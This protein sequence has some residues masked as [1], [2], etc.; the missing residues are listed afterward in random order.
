MD[1]IAILKSLLKQYKRS[2]GLIT[3]KLSHLSISRLW[4][5]DNHVTH[6]LLEIV[7]PGL[8]SVKL[9]FVPSAETSERMDSSN[10]ELLKIP[11]QSSAIILS[12]L[13]RKCPRLK[14]LLLV[15][16]GNNALFK[17]A[18]QLLAS[19]EKPHLVELT[20]DDGS[21]QVPDDFVPLISSVALHHAETLQMLAVN[22]WPRRNDR[23][24]F[25]QL[26]GLTDTNS[27]QWSTLNEQSLKTVGLPARCI[28]PQSKDNTMSHLIYYGRAEFTSEKLDMLYSQ[29]IAPIESPQ[30]RAREI[31][32]C[33]WWATPVHPKTIHQYF[34][35]VK[36]VIPHVESLVEHPEGVRLRT[37]LRT[38]A[39]LAL[40]VAPHNDLELLER[41]ENLATKVDSFGSVLEIMLTEAIPNG[42]QNASLPALMQRPF[43]KSKFVQSCNS[44]RSFFFPVLQK[45]CR[46][47]NLLLELLAGDFDV[48]TR[49]ERGF[50]FMDCILKSPKENDCRICMSTI[51]RSPSLLASLVKNMEVTHL[52]LIY[53]TELSP[54][55]SSPLDL[56]LPQRVFQLVEAA[57]SDQVFKIIY[58]YYSDWQYGQITAAIP[59]VHGESRKLPKRVT[60][61]TKEKK[62][63]VKLYRGSVQPSLATEDRIKRFLR[64][65]E[66]FIFPEP[67][68]EETYDDYY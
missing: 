9:S 59:Y 18:M 15:C 26:F 13:K 16:E 29:L 60:A 36:W 27:N 14:T 42:A 48:W 38:V 22:V 40:A 47:L 8:R 64:G 12:L 66:P 7:A 21:Y 39:L 68:E 50:S 62:S 55:Y 24:P 31:M 6:Q 51:F 33:I 49:N 57:D 10:I 67:V 53:S 3:P 30:R 54:S 20:I 23:Q 35:F 19:T 46:P 52:I 44:S 45:G 41:L 1:I 65:A 25:Q 34:P 11:S 43:W 5:G 56:A 28:R 17:E 61:S 2:E 58:Q 32:R 4:S 37:L 63:F